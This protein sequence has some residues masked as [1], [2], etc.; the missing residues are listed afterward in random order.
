MKINEELA[1]KPGHLHYPA[2]LG[3]KMEID[4]RSFQIFLYTA[5]VSLIMI[6]FSIAGMR[7]TVPYVIPELIC[8][9][10]D[11]GAAFIQAFEFLILGV[12][13]LI[14]CT[15][16]KIAD[17][18]VF[19]IYVLLLGITILTKE[20]VTDAFVII[21]SIGGIVRSFTAYSMMCDYEQLRNTEGFPI[22]SLILAEKEEQKNNGSADPSVYRNNSGQTAMDNAVA[23]AAPVFTGVDNGS[24]M[25]ALDPISIPSN[26]YTEKRYLP[27]G[28]KVSGILGS[29]M[30]TR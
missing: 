26:D 14:G 22:F 1:E 20:Y 19:L 5:L 25:P 13:S 2:C 8:G 28:K 11:V 30:R 24:G 4:K 9:G 16:Y 27:Q 17:F 18:L 6:I 7:F 23:A 29:P 21:I 15:K 12:L 10:N 3:R